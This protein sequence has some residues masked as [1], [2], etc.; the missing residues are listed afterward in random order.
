MH[1]KRRRL[2][3]HPPIVETQRIARDPEDPRARGVEKGRGEP[4]VERRGGGVFK[5][6][7][8]F[9]R[10][11]APC[12]VLQG[13]RLHVGVL[14][15]FDREESR[16]EERR[17]IGASRDAGGFGIPGHFNEHRYPIGFGRREFRF[18]PSFEFGGEFL[19]QPLGQERKKLR[20][21]RISGELRKAAKYDRTERDRKK[22][23]TEG[24]R[25][26]TE[27]KLHIDW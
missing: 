14:D 23:G 7:P 25:S 24:R 16:I 22:Y 27:G 18:H 20:V 4:L 8:V 6:R 26:G 19:H 12:G 17:Q 15:G 10:N 1:G 9:G 2:L 5:K 21:E 11:E 13:E 3:Q